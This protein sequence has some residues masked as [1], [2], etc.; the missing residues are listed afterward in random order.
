MSTAWIAVGILFGDSS[1]Q[2][3]EDR[4]E[5]GRRIQGS[6]LARMRGCSVGPDVLA[7]AAVPRAASRR[8]AGRC[9]DGNV[10]VGIACVA[11]LQSHQPDHGPGQIV[12][13]HRLAHVEHEHLPARRHGA[14]LDDERGR[15]RDRHEV[16]DRVGMRDRHR[17]AGLDLA[18]EPP[19]HR[20][21]AV[22]HVAEA[23]H[24]EDG[25]APAV[26]PRA[27]AGPS[28]P[29]ACWRP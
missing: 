9:I 8:R 21:R 24:G 15:L 25:A 10:A 11:H 20:A 1:A 28:R 3:V 23:H 6:W 27:P 16:A 14:G 19:H 7:R 13:L 29:G 26:R 17:A 5:P 4:G 22:E 12:D 2:I 18:A